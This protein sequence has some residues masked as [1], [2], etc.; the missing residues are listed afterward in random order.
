MKAKEL[1]GMEVL[2]ANARK[3]GKIAD[4]EVDITKGIVE[5]INVKAG[6][7]KGYVIGLDRIHVVGERMIL[8]VREDEL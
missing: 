7:S 4:F 6:F 8:K 2:D 3:I 5:N 1:L